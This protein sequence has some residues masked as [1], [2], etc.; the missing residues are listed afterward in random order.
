MKGLESLLNPDEHLSDDDK[1]LQAE[2]FATDLALLQHR[3]A[4]AVDPSAV[5]AEWCEECG[6]EIPKR[7]RLAVPGVTLCVECTR[8]EERK[9]KLRL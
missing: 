3:Q 2:Q 4:H 9:E 8:E 7:R 5:S 1:G 6:N